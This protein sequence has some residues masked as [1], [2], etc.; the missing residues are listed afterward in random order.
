MP[1]K[2]IIVD[3]HEIMREGLCS[4]IQKEQDMEV[5]GTA[6]NGRQAVKRVRKLSPDVII[7]DISMSEMNGIEAT[8]QIISESNS[9][10]VIGLSVHSSSRFV[11]EM[12]KA[13]A[14]G[15]LLKD[16]AFEELI[17][18]IRTVVANNAYL[19]PAIVSGIIKGYVA[20]ITENEA[21]VSSVLT[22][23]ETEI[24]Q[25]IAEGHKTKQ[26]ASKLYIS[27]KTVEVHRRRIMEKLSIHSIAGLT[28]F[29]IQEGY[30]TLN[31]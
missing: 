25:L 13:G 12:L 29:A 11:G 15:Y 14:C 10:K 22:P 3:D 30:T 20:Y 8:R 31:T 2:V 21:S 23:R 26:I 18:A 27:V 5:V 16:C 9:A 28:K 24:L 17:Q 1:I 4:L 19:S 6:D 7:M